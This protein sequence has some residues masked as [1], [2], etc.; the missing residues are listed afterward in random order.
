MNIVCVLI[1]SKDFQPE[2]VLWLKAQCDKYIPHRRFVCYT[3]TDIPG[4]DQVRLKTPWPKWWAKM[5]AYGDSGLTGPALV[6]DLDTVIVSKFQPNAEQLRENWI[7]RHYTRD[8]FNAPEE[9]A[10][11]VMLVTE[12]FRKKVYNHFVQ[13]PRKYMD[14]CMSDD[15]RYFKKYFD[16][17]LLRFQDEFW[18]QFVSYKLHVLP[19]GVREDNVFINFHGL[20]R[21]WDI[22]RPWIPKL[23]ESDGHVHRS[24]VS[25]EC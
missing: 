25:A 13:N 1:A 18:D 6:M 5:E 2:H 22:S 24:S 3:D 10:C 4:V 21:P 8:G 9:F 19:H 23:G 11:G 7:M 14:E 17:D 16:K 20:P 15:Q 12:A